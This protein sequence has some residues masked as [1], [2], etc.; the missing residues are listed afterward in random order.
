MRRRLYTDEAVRGHHDTIPQHADPSLLE[1]PSAYLN[2]D[3]N[4]GIAVRWDNNERTIIR[5]TYT[6]R[7]TWDELY[8]ALAEQAALQASVTH[9]VAILVDARNTN[10]V[11]E[12]FI[13]QVKRVA[14]RMPPHTGL[15][16]IVSGNPFIK[17]LFL[18]VSKLFP[19]MIGDML[20]VAT[21]EGAYSLLHE[22][23]RIVSGL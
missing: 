16:I 14:E 7:W 21:I 8:T 20:F 1:I 6:A 5:Y 22:R 11:P 18:L 19:H 15:R 13:A 12:G 4:M 17:S 23:E 3:H 9:E 10:I 2:M